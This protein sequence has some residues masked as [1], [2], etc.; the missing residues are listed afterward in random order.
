MSECPEWETCHRSDS[1]GKHQWCQNRSFWLRYYGGEEAMKA[2]D[3]MMYKL[4][5]I[6]KRSALPSD[7]YSATADRCYY[8]EREFNDRTRPT[9]DHIVPS[10]RG[11]INGVMNYRRCCERCNR[12]KGDMILEEFIVFLEKLITRKGWLDA[13][14]HVAVDTLQLIIYNSRK[15][16]TTI[17]PYQ[18]RLSS[19]TTTGLNIGGGALQTRLSMLASNPPPKMMTEEEREVLIEARGLAASRSIYDRS[20]YDNGAISNYPCHISQPSGYGV[21]FGKAA[22]GPHAKQAQRDLDEATQT[23]LEMD[24]LRTPAYVPGRIENW[25]TRQQDM[26][27]A[28]NLMREVETGSIEIVTAICIPS[29]N[30]HQDAQ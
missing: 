15:L 11:G 25:D 4:G 7:T 13:N 10:A 17:A 28:E 8:C 23:R 2:M 14:Y 27:R 12:L 5:M 29:P 30:F 22:L 19:S 21:A 24:D 6:G 18:D 1:C 20:I 3:P 26:T 16:I 9:R